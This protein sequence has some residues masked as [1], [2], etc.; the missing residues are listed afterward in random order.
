[1]NRRIERG[2]KR[3]I[4]I[5]VG[6]L[7]LAVAESQWVSRVS[8]QSLP[9]AVEAIGKARVATRI[10]YTTAHPDDESAGLLAYLARG[11]YADVAILTIT[12]GQGG[13]NAIGRNRTASSAPSAPQSCWQ[14][15]RTMACI[16]TSR[17]LSIPASRKARAHHEDLGANA[18]HGRYGARDSHL[19]AADRNQ[20]LG[21]REERAWA[22]SGERNPDAASG[23]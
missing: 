7:A 16:N 22:A 4:V 11:V 8:A 10:L 1:M 14:R 19:P 12:R 23:C 13:Q 18:P 15:I 17:A 5:A 21:R 20:R 3:S 9:E 2:V 6:L